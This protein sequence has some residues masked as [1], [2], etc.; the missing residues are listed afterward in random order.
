[1]LYSK[2]YEQYSKNIRVQ[3]YYLALYQSHNLQNRF[4]LIKQFGKILGEAPRAKPVASS[5]TSE[6]RNPSDLS[7]EALAKVEVYPTSPD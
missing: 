1:M 2:H 5:H 6:E 4:F 3:V 7:S